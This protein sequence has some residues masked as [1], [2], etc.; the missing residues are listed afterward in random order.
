MGPEWYYLASRCKSNQGL[1]VAEGTKGRWAISPDER[2]IASHVD[3]KVLLTDL[4]NRGHSTLAD[5]GDGGVLDFLPDGK[6]LA[7][8]TPEGLM[9]VDLASGKTRSV[10]EDGAMSGLAF[11]PDGKWGASAVGGKVRLWNST[12]DRV[13]W[14]RPAA[15]HAVHA[16]SPDSKWL[17][18]KAWNGND[19]T[20]W[21]VADGTDREIPLDESFDFIRQMVF[22][23]RP[24][25]HHR[26]WIWLRLDQS[27]NREADTWGPTSVARDSIC[28]RI[29]PIGRRNP[30]R[31]WYRG[32]CGR[33]LGSRY[34]K[35]TLAA[36]LQASRGANPVHQ[37]GNSGGTWFSR[38][39]RGFVILRTEAKRD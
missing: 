8:G 13:A 24:V 19:F 12:T 34:R 39:C 5:G 22:C 10:F 35:E 38:S 9:V 31:A 15:G 21:N 25:L 29:G 20:V 27:R 7:L 37:Q 3:G 18:S 17:I 23:R 26:W 36:G 1:I 4:A 16:F 28:H 30:S 2:F 33:G 14:S 11:S 6:R 32:Q